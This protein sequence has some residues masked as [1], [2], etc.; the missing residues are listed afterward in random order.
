M[1]PNPQQIANKLQGIRAKVVFDLPLGA[2]TTY[3][4]GGPADVAIMPQTLQDLAQTVRILHELCVPFVVIG[5]GSNI[6]VSDIGVRGA[7]VLTAALKQISVVDQKI[8][9]GAGAQSHQV[10]VAAKNADL[11]GAE[12]L[13]FLPGTLGGACFMNATAYGSEISKVLAEAQ[14]VDS[15]GELKRVLLTPE[16]FSYKHSPFQDS[17]ETIAQATLTLQPGDP[18]QIQTKMDEI[19]R[20]RREKKEMD[21]PC[22]GCVFKNNYEIGIPSWKLIDEC[23]LRGFRIGDAQVAPHHANFVINTGNA[24]ATQVMQVIKHVRKTVHEKT[25]HL[26]E[27]EVQVIGEWDEKR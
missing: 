18:A 10:A 3:E 15:R 11:S 21:F 24:T 8:V 4:I 2:H 17:K 23:G 14:T 9:A 5:G 13:A 26:L 7:V 12:F 20:S 22:C 16:M 27:L 6:L 19:Q 1:N 25:G